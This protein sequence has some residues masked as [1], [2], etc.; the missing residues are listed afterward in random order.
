LSFYTGDPRKYILFG[1]PLTNISCYRN[2]EIRISPD[3]LVGGATAEVSGESGDTENGCTYITTY[4]TEN[5]WI[6]NW[7]THEKRVWDGPPNPNE[8]AYSKLGDIIF[9]GL[10]T[11]RDSVFGIS[12]FIPTDLD[13]GIG[14]ISGY[15]WDEGCGGKAGKAVWITG[16]DTTIQDTIGPQIEVFVNGK[17]MP[18]LVKVGKRFTISAIIQDPS[19]IMLQE[20]KGIRL[21]VTGG[22]YYQLED[23]FEYD[24]GSSTRGEL[25]TGIESQTMYPVDTL[26]LIVRDNIGN[27]SKLKFWVEKTFGEVVVLESPINYPNPVKGEKTRIEFYSSKEGMGTIRIFTISGR[28]IKTLYLQNVRVG[29]NS[30]EWNTRDEFQDRIGNGIYIYKIE[31]R[32]IGDESSRK[33]SSCIGKMMI[34][35]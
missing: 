35:R 5:K 16:R 14:K 20:G 25:V 26:I 11:L 7:N 30:E 28:L 17:K 21:E 34:M 3:S 22:Q 15:L 8:I 2:N 18:K 32:G 10:T 24:I 23:K 27:E 9:R 31:V 6:Y 13:S 29:I 1:E 12:F 4:G 19:G 33:S